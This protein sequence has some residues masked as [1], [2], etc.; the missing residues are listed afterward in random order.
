MTLRQLRK[1]ALRKGI[2][3][4]TKSRKIERLRVAGRHI[5][6][7]A[8]SEDLEFREHQLYVLEGHFRCEEIKPDELITIGDFIMERPPPIQ[9]WMG[10]EPAR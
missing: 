8:W 3:R 9:K 6:A 7:G 5:L 4:W 1:V 10:Y 2:V